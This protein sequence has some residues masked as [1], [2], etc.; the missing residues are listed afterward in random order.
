MT[1]IVYAIVVNYPADDI[2]LTNSNGSIYTAKI[3]GKSSRCL[4]NSLTVKLM[5]A[6]YKVRLQDN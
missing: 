4:S 3:L 1:T 2:G 6:K 5:T